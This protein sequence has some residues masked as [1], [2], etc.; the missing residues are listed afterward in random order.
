M[1]IASNKDESEKV[2][3]IIRDVKGVKSIVNHIIIKD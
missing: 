1:G 2:I 3:E